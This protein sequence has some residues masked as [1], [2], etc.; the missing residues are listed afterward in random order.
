MSFSP[1]ERKHSDRAHYDLERVKALAG[2][3]PPAITVEPRALRNARRFFP[4]DVVDHHAEISDVISDLR[5]NEFR[6]RQKKKGKSWA[7]IY[8]VMYYEDYYYVKLKIEPDPELGEES[9][10]VL[11]WKPWTD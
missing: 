3:N 10:A 9:V 2:H 6:F 11:S 5:Q 8:C 7:D 4:D 1:W